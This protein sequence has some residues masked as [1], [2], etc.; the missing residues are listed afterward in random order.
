MAYSV[1]RVRVYLRS[2]NYHEFFIGYCS[3]VWGLVTI[4]TQGPSFLRFIHGWDSTKI[5]LLSGLPHLFRSIMAIVISQC[6]DYLLRSE[7]LSRNSVRKSATA[8]ATILNGFFVLGLAYSG[9][10]ATTACVC[11]IFATTCHAGVSRW[12]WK[13]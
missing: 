2:F 12:A 1:V 10:D 9:C 5:G 3:G 13:I 6:M 7:M 8:V 11:I 4:L